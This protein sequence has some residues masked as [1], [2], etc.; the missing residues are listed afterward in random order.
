MSVYREARRLDLFKSSKSPRGLKNPVYEAPDMLE[1]L[2]ERGQTESWLGPRPKSD[3]RYR[4]R[5][6]RAATA[7]LGD[8]LHFDVDDISPYRYPLDGKHYETDPVSGP[9][10]TCPLCNNASA[11]ELN[12]YYIHNLH[13]KKAWGKYHFDPAMVIDHLVNHVGL[14]YGAALDEKL[15][16]GSDKAALALKV[17]RTA[18]RMGLCH[19]RNDR[20]DEDL[21]MQAIEVSPSVFPC[22]TALDPAPEVRGRPVGERAKQWYAYD[23]KTELGALRPWEDERVETEVTKRANDAIVFYDEMLS[24]RRM[25]LNI[26]NEIMDSEPPE[27]QAKNYAAAIAAVREVKG[28]AMDMAKLALIA[29]KFGDEKDRARQLSPSMMAMLND[30]GVF[31]KPT[32]VA[33][34]SVEVLDD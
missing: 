23:G 32:D 30:I 8:I 4:E 15:A 20:A 31:S 24:V 28:V 16:E 1:R 12:E 11:K 18:R 21:E 25:A 22:Q 10:G 9:R 5:E 26:H 13:R 14:I 29:T 33:G 19:R 27:G 2:A 17:A 7:L 6:E 3:L 34:E